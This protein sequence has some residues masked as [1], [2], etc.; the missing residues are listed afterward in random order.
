VREAS[1]KPLDHL[2]GVLPPSC[3]PEDQHA[4][5]TL[6]SG[7]AVGRDHTSRR[8]KTAATIRSQWGPL[9]R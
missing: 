4:A 8:A 5:R 9:K 6:S 1:A 2:P 7:S 3:V